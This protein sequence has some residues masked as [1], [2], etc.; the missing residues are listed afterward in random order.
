MA[1]IHISLDYHI[2][3]LIIC[4]PFANDTWDDELIPKAIVSNAERDMNVLLR[5][6]YLR[7][8]FED[9][10]S[11]LVSSL[12]KL[13]F[14][15]L[16]NINDQTPPEALHYTR[17]SLLLVLKGLREQGR[18]YY[19]TRTIY[20][21]V[22]NQLRPQEAGLLHGAEDPETELDKVPELE[23]EVQSTWSPSV[24][25]ISDDLSEEELSKL[26]KR[27]LKIDSGVASDDGEDDE[28]Y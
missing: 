5:L 26:A 12:T 17:S 27:F 11:Y 9:P 25:D 6:Y 2:A 24:V 8:G 13:G 7:H 14:M 15:A 28:Q 1:N 10:Q 19:L 4:Q 18:N 22:K 3:L 20:Y 16:H 23:S 21:I